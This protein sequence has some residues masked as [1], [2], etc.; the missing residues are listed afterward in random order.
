M[1]TEE[2]AAKNGRDEIM[3]EAVPD[4]KMLMIP[5]GFNANY[6]KLYYGSESP[7]IHIIHYFTLSY[8]SVFTYFPLLLIFRLI[9]QTTYNSMMTYKSVFKQ[10][11][12]TTY[13]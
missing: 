11:L 7:L 2:E 9:S 3:I 1:S 4:A 13:F 8:I 6:L 12:C 5:E 10:C